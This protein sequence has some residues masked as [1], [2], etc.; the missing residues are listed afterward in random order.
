M[1]FCFPRGRHAGSNGEIVYQTD[2]S[3]VRVIQPTADSGNHFSFAGLAGSSYSLVDLNRAG[4]PLLEIVS[5]P[6][7]RSAEEALP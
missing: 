5:E 1:L 7:I 2:G 4:T 6:D 3:I